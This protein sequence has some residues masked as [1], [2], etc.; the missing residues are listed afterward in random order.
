[1]RDMHPIYQIIFTLLILAMLPVLLVG[2]AAQWL[3]DK[4]TNRLRR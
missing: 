2:C 4:R 3:V 1:M